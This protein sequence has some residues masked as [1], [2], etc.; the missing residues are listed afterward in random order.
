MLLVRQ[1]L[2]LVKLAAPFIS[3]VFKKIGA[4][5]VNVIGTNKEIA[6]LMTQEDFESVDLS[7][8]K[9]SVIIPVVVLF[10]TRLL[11]IYFHVMVLNVLLVEDQIL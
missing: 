8:V 2:L 9:D 7:Q 10:M 4:N 1:L 3:K 6:C 11:R 5:N